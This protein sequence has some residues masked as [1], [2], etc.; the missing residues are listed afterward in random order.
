[1]QFSPG[2]TTISFGA[3]FACFFPHSFNLNMLFFA[4]SYQTTY[5]YWIIRGRNNAS[6]NAMRNTNRIT[7]TVSH[8]ARCFSQ[9]SQCFVCCFVVFIS[10]SH[11]RCCLCWGLQTSSCLVVVH[12]FSCRPE[13]SSSSLRVSIWWLYFSSLFFSLSLSLVVF[14]WLR[15][16][17]FPC[18]L[19]LCMCTYVLLLF[20]PLHCFLTFRF[21]SRCNL[22]M[23]LP[24]FLWLRMPNNV[25]SSASLPKT[26]AS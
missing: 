3:I 2:I 25:K 12:F 7:P 19:A 23:L 24:L 10:L 5:N 15:C 1:M 11:F 22:I 16:Y 8:C 4:C 26:A 20:D 13:K 9:L 6:A 18:P 21:F 17:S 14:S